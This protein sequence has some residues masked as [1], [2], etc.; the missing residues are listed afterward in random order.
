MN[1]GGNNLGKSSSMHKNEFEYF[2]S[3]D[4]GEFA[5]YRMPKA[6]F[7]DERFSGLSFE[8]KSLYGVLLDRM[9]LSAKNG[10]LDKNNRVYIIY[11][12]EELGILLGAGRDKVRRLLGMLDTEKGC[13]LIERKH[14]GLGKP[15]IIFVRN[16]IEKESETDKE[17]AKNSC[18]K[19]VENSDCEVAEADSTL[20]RLSEIRASVQRIM[21]HQEC[22]KYDSNNTNINN[23]KR[24]I[25]KDSNTDLS[26]ASDDAIF[27][28]SLSARIRDGDFFD[29]HNITEPMFYECFT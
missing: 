27:D 15:D 22:G 14:Q 5:F 7:T 20:S 17:S 2:N 25:H 9:C 24:V 21:R 3:G 26:G 10:W 18:G 13:G 16:F 11:P 12:V 8:A 4:I 29:M 28:A 19:S 1:E 6:L 23:K